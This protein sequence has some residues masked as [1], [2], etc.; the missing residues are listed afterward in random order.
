MLAAIVIDGLADGPLAFNQ[1]ARYTSP[2]GR[3][4]TDFTKG[5]VY[6]R[7]GAKSEPAT[8]DDFREFL[9]TDVSNPSAPLGWTA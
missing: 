2:Q 7:H 9:L 3:Q 1:T 8:R 5:S 6:F 4:K